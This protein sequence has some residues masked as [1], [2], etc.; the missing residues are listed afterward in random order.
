MSTFLIPLMS[1]GGATCGTMER[2]GCLRPFRPV[3]QR[4]YKAGVDQ[5]V[6][7]GAECS[8]YSVTE[9]GAS[10]MS[11]MAERS[12]VVA[13]T[14]VLTVLTGV[15][16]M[17]DAHQLQWG[18]CTSIKPMQDFDPERFNGTWYVLKKLKT[19]SRCMSTNFLLQD[20]KFLVTEI[21][22]PILADLTAFRATVSN[23]GYL[24]FSPSQ[25]A[26]M[27]LNWEGNLL[28]E[29]IKTSFTIVDT[30]YDTYAVDV[31]C[32]SWMLFKRV[33]ATILAR[34]PSL[35]EG[36][37]EEPIRTSHPH[38]TLFSPSPQKHTHTAGEEIS[39]DFD[40]DTRYMD[41]IDHSNCFT[42]DEVDYNIKIDENGLNL[43]G[44]EREEELQKLDTKEKAEQY[45]NETLPEKDQEA[46][47][48]EE[49]ADV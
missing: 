32:Q 14:V 31:E 37:I 15:L 5:G 35:P 10:T 49:E 24:H 22:T 21:R 23:E 40:V 43:L 6:S 45:F 36:R 25:P 27:E 7:F 42:P 46:E 8:S 20:G 2:N 19:S 30:D 28:D 16:E 18:S 39:E 11:G 48:E 9:G 34:E 4:V 41:T 38:F 26:K 1:V 33:S 29:F 3:N 17:A 44:M 12:S 47:E 13:L